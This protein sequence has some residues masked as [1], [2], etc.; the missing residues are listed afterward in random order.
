M[1]VPGRTFARRKLFVR[2]TARCAAAAAVPRPPSRR[3]NGT[4]FD[5]VTNLLFLVANS[6]SREWQIL[7]LTPV[8]D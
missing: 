1:K 4:Q 2:L 6:Y 5:M 8:P 3:R 7:L